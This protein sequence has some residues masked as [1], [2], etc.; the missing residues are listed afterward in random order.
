MNF[1][2]DLELFTFRSLRIYMYKLDIFSH[3][4]SHQNGRKIIEFITF[5]T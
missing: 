5:F 1:N 2:V 3:L 4:G